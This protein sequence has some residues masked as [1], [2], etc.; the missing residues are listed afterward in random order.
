MEDLVIKKA[1]FTREEAEFFAWGLNEAAGGLFTHL[2]GKKANRLLVKFALQHDNCFSLDHVI[3]ATHNN[4]I[5]GMASS[6]DYRAARKLPKKFGLTL[7]GSI[8]RAIIVYSALKDIFTFMSKHKEDEWYLQ[9]IAVAPEAR[10]KGVSRQLLEE[11]E[12][13]AQSNNL[14]K[15]AL[16]VEVKNTR[17][18]NLYKSFGFFLEKTSNPSKLAQ[19]HRMTKNF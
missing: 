11:V 8:F 14:H 6:M 9:A 16:D 17:A 2:F 10:R 7:R 12:K 19:V 4:K 13:S 3:F 5:L 1:E 18:I 15:L